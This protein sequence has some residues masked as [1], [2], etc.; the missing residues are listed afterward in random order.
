MMA[1]STNPA[2]P[3]PRVHID[4]HEATAASHSRCR[5]V[6]VVRGARMIALIRMPHMALVPERIA[7]LGRWPPG[8]AGG[9]VVA[10]PSVAHR[11]PAAI[12]VFPVQN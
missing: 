6:R 7:A 3:P 5:V 1:A 12:N 8:D 10:G 9:A 11:R 2:A 4:N